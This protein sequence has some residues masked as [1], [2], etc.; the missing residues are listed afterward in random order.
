MAMCCQKDMPFN[1]K[2]DTCDCCVL[3]LQ[4]LRQHFLGRFVVEQD[5]L[6]S[7]CVCMCVCVCER[8]D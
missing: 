2:Q 5:H 4:M 8:I 6:V 1:K 7:V 3:A